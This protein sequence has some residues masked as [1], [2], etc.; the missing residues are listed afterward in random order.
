MSETDTELSDTQTAILEATRDALQDHGYAG[1]SMSKVAS[2]FDGSQSLIHYHFDDRNGLLTAFLRYERQQFE[3]SLAELPDDPS[4]RLECLVNERIRNIRAT[5]TGLVRAYVGLHGAAL[6]IDSIRQELIALDDTL[7][8]AF[9]ETVA[10]GIECGQ[11]ADRDPD[12]VARLLL[13][14]H[15]SAFIRVTLAEPTEPV[16]DAVI[17]TVLA[18]LRDTENKQHTLQTND[19]GEQAPNG[20]GD[21]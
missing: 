5:D 7:F 20:G 3:A 9:R 2:T 14:G 6:D 11:F 15:D 21:P 1:L 13:A 16:A 17:R 19:T 18:D 4:A 10:D 8:M 12:T